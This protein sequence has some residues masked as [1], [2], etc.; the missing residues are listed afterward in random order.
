MN[1]RYKIAG[2]LTKLTDWRYFYQS[3]ISISM[4]RKNK[5][6]FR[7]KDKLFHV[8]N[9]NSPDNKI[10]LYLHYLWGSNVD[11]L[12]IMMEQKINLKGL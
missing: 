4:I 9:L 10:E 12:Y 8:Y 2:I 1:K 6:V 5:I 3:I 11:S 7:T